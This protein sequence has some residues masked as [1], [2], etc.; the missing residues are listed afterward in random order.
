MAFT[1]AQPLYGQTGSYAAQ[2][3][4][5]L[6]E[7]LAVRS[8][9]GNI[10]STTT[11]DLAVATTGVANA[12]VTIAAGHVWIPGSSGQGFYYA[13]N[14]AAI[15]V[16]LAANASGSTRNDLIYVSV[17]DPNLSTGLPNV[18]IV[19]LA[20]TPGG[21]VPSLPA[22][23]ATPLA[24]I[25][26]PTGFTSGTT[27]TAGWITDR[28]TKANLP[29]IATTTPTGT[30]VPSPTNGSLVYDTTASA[31]KTYDSVGTT[32]QPYV[33]A[34]T[35]GWSDGST[36]FLPVV[37]GTAANRAALTGMQAGLLAY[38]TDTNK[39]YVYDGTA[40][41]LTTENGAWDTW[42]PTTAGI[43]AGTGATTGHAYMQMGKTVHFRF[44]ITF[45]TTPAF[46]APVTFT[47]PVAPLANSQ[48]FAVGD[49]NGTGGPWQL[50]ARFSTGSTMALYYSRSAA[51]LSGPDTL[52]VVT[53]G[54]TPVQPASGNI[55]V[56]QGTY[57]AA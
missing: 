43:T 44:R 40:W 10:L 18:Q 35:A 46:T 42:V 21:G 36:R 34:I 7:G 1:F 29:N 53:T 5:L 3:D 26:V 48:P 38:E 6:I 55:L 39:F 15:T 20:G 32:W 45:G 17:S 11:G 12:S 19:T 37:S 30:N 23:N 31:L 51:A 2:Q 14:D 16:T 54:A 13:Y 4:R 27:V 50:Q 41:V 52:A 57:E 47:L 25:A 49:Y 33:K 8:G 22:S 9:V 28:R 56:V 24:S